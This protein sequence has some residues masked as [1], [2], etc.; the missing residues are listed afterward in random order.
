MERLRARFPHALALRFAP[1]GGV[2]STRRPVPVEGR[3]AHAVA[4]DFV[5]HVRGEPAGE[6]ESAL[7][8]EAFE[9]CGEDRDLSREVAAG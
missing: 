6:A 5:D 7:L 1:E 8:R 4:L 2:P 3:S 9:C